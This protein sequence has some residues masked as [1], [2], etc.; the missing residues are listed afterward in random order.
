MHQDRERPPGRRGQ[1]A[2]ARRAVEDHARVVTTNIHAAAFYR[3]AQQS[4]DLPYAI[5]MLRL[6]VEADPSFELAVADLDALTGAPPRVLIG[7]QMNWERHHIEVVRTAAAGNLS[8]AADLLRELIG[9]VGCDPL[10]FRIVS[11]LRRRTGRGD[12]LEDLAAQ[13]PGCHPACPRR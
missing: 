8:R 4:V 2:F 7:R 10:A 5:R 9:S 6:A 1:P 13:L 12:E 3:Q 11:Q